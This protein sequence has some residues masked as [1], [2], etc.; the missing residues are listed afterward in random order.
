ML[1]AIGSGRANF[2]A[3]FTPAS[4]SGLQWWITAKTGIT[5]DPASQWNDQSSNANHATQGTGANQPDYQADFA[6]TG[7]PALVFDGS[8]DLMTIGSNISLT[9]TFTMFFVYTSTSAVNARMLLGA[10]TP[11]NKIGRN[12]G[13]S[14]IRVLDAGSSSGSLTVS[15]S[16]EIMWVKRDAS[17]KVDAAI[18][19]AGATRLYSDVAQSGTS[20]WNQLGCGQTTQNWIGA[21]HSVVIYNTDVTG[22]DFT[23]M[24]TYLTGQWN[25]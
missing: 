5:G 22:A 20:V 18:Y 3:T 11:S 10:A 12:N 4:L 16:R 7:L 9:G 2:S 15:T 19:P 13:P 23:S 8:N 1:T 21:I 24:T 25:L 17:N 6:S 14:F